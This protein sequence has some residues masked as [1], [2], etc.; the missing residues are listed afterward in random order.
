MDGASAADRGGGTRGAHPEGVTQA[1]ENRQARD[2]DIAVNLERLQRT[3]AAAAERSGRPAQAVTLVAV[4]KTV[5]ADRIREAYLAGQ[6][7]FGENRVQEAVAKVAALAEDML[8]ARWHLIGHLQSNKAGAAVEAFSLIESV[9]SLKLATRLNALAARHGKSVPVL[10]E[11]NV[12]G[13]ES[14]EGF[15]ADDFWAAAPRLLQLPHLAVRGL[16]TVAPLVHDPEEVR[17]VFR[18]LREMRDRAAEH[19]GTA[20]F[21][22]LSMGMS[23]DFEVAIEEGAT[24]VRVGRALFGERPPT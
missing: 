18:A 24:I 9:D 2:R 17:S 23:A 7:V 21:R 4:S 19:F 22:E 10:L 5:P 3:I 6:R 14:K 15:S 8:D 12:A 13:E 20:D 1:R 11:V 16:M